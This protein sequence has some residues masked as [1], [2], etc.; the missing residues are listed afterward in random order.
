VCGHLCLDIIPAFPSAGSQ[1]WFRPG[2][3]SV[4]G[5]ATVAPGGAVS[6]VGLSLHKLGF[7]VSLVA[8]IGDDPLGPLVLG[9]VRAAGDSLPAGLTIL[10]GESTSYTIVLSPP[11]VD[12]IFLHCPGANDAFTGEEIPGSILEGAAVFHFGYPPLLR[13]IWSDGGERLRKLFTRARSAGAF[14][15]LDMS[16]PDPASPS[17]QAD[18]AGFLDHTLPAVDLFSPS[19]EELL[20]MMDRT[21]YTRLCAAGGPDAIIRSVTLEE[22]GA[23]AGRIIDRGVSAVLIKLGDRGAYLRTAPGGLRGRPRVWHDR[24]LYSPC[25]AVPRVAGTTGS[26]DATIAG[27]LG[28]VVEGYDPETALRMAV[29]V[30]ACCVEAPDATSGIGSWDETLGRIAAG[31]KRM[32]DVPASPGWTPLPDGAWKGPNDR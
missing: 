10:P 23:L 24:E 9:K 12:R 4:I 19:I 28:A 32:P 11:G 8:G 16:L 21:A 15:S 26:G 29:A 20:W 25:F 14:A 7:P 1:D 5:P 31:W 18:W 13:Q 30:G 6:N 3:L 17:G 22:L 2:R 27:F